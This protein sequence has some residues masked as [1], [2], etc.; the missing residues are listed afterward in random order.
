M[1]DT[2]I[3]KMLKELNEIYAV[4]KKDHES[5]NDILNLDIYY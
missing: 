2:S 3:G 4:L 1:T 5:K